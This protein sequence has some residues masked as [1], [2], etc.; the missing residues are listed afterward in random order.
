VWPEFLYCRKKK[1][2]DSN[3]GAASGF[4]GKPFGFGAAEANCTVYSGV[5]GKVAAHVSTWA[6]LFCLTNLT[7]ENFTSTD[8]LATKT[9]HT[10]ALA[11]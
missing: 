1:L 11:W 10:E 8:F 3:L 4:A 5:N 2:F 7:D 9:F 6:S